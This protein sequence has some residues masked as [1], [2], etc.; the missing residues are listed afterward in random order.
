MDN[1]MQPSRTLPPPEDITLS[2]GSHIIIR[3]IQPQDASLL[4]TTFGMLSAQSIYFR[5]MSHKKALTNEEAR[6]FANVDYRTKMAF[7]AISEENGQPLILGVARYALLDPAHPD[8]AESAVAVGDGFQH[9][10]IGKLLLGR[11]VKY[12]RTQGI[13]YLRGVI[14]LENQVMIEIIKKGGFPHQQQ[15]VD[16]HYQITIDIGS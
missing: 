8:L 2:D 11:L 3:P 9:R 6:N 16:G 7:V 13:R 5:F 15:F 1:P 12:A 14:L 4:Q 10:G